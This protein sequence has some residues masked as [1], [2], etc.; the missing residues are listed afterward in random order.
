MF[1][2]AWKRGQYEQNSVTGLFERRC[3]RCEKTEHGRG[4]ISCGVGQLG[5]RRN[6]REGCLHLDPMSADNKDWIAR[7]ARHAP[8]AEL[9]PLGLR[10]S[11]V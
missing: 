2:Y 9:L 7:M 8:H 4:L 1:S 10:E 11:S 6:P 5:A 3:V